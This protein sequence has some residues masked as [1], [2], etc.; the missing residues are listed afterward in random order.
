MVERLPIIGVMGSGQNDWSTYA[1]PLGQLLALKPVHLLTGAG[2]GVMASVSK[3][4]TDVEGRQGLALGVVPS[5]I[6]DGGT[7]APRA[8][9]P[10]PYVE[11]SIYSPLGAYKGGDLQH[12]SRNH[13]N[14]MTSHG[15]VVLPGTNGTKNEVMIAQAMNKPF[16]A[17][18]SKE[19]FAGFPEGVEPTEDLSQIEEFIDGIIKMAA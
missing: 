15:V 14:I 16:I 19:A 4:F 9:Y 11:I 10:N 6:E 8:G 2:Q 7:Y 1:G 17:F 5:D 12:V 3:A 18:G 13:T